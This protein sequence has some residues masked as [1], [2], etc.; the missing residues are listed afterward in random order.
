MTVPN[1]A[2]SI[3]SASCCSGSSVCSAPPST[4][5]SRYSVVPVSRRCLVRIQSAPSA[6][7]SAS[8]S[9]REPRV[10]ER[11]LVG[12]VERQG[13]APRAGAATARAGRARPA[14]TRADRAGRS[15]C[16]RCRRRRGGPRRRKSMSSQSTA[17]APSTAYSATSAPSRSSRKSRARSPESL[18]V[19]SRFGERWLRASPEASVIWSS[20]IAW[21]AQSPASR[22]V[23]SGGNHA[24]PASARSAPDARERPHSNSPERGVPPGPAVRRGVARRALPLDR[25]HGGERAAP[26]GDQ[27]VLGRVVEGVLQDLLLDAAALE[28]VGVEP[29]RGPR[30]RLARGHDVA[31]AELRPE[32]REVE[33]AVRGPGLHEQRPRGHGERARQRDDLERRAERVAHDLH[34]LAQGQRLLVGAVVDLPARRGRRAHRQQHRVREVL[35]VAVASRA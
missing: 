17:F 1:S 10:G 14:G 25:R 29:A 13:C 33:H 31:V 24:Q 5:A 7:Y 22:G 19:Q 27:R 12:V 21:V 9:K 30:Q 26:A 23:G 32:L 35:G 16:C 4:S 3:G 8:A 28:R 6:K 11:R 2:L 20:A 15:G 34:D 18:W